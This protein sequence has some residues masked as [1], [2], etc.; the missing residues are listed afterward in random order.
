MN[1]RS[2]GISEQRYYRWQ[3]EYSDLNVGQTKLPKE[4][5]SENFRFRKAMAALR[6]PHANV[7]F[8]I[9]ASVKAFLVTSCHIPS[10]RRSALADIAARG[11]CFSSRSARGRLMMG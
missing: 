9:A 4:L 7:A 8:S 1:C 6:T 11:S 3:R 5:E 10:A 2:L